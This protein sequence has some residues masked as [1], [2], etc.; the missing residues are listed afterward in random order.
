M[1]ERA[2]IP[3]RYEHCTLENYDTDLPSSHRS[4][5]IGSGDCQK[6]CRGISGGDGWD[7]DCLLTGSIGVGKTHL[8]VGILQALVTERGATGLF[9]DYRDLLK[10][11]QNSY[12]EQVRGDRAGGAAAGV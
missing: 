10:Q 4:Q 9:Y 8:A 3:R 1:L 5:A 2:H 11:V 7:G 6:V 12:N